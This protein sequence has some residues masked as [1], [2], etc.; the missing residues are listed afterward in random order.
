MKFSCV[1]SASSQVLQYILF[2]VTTFCQKKIKILLGFVKKLLQKIDIFLWQK[3][4]TWYDFFGK[5]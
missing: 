4:A 2:A 1:Y 3:L 5:T